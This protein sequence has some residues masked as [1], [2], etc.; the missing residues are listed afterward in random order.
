[1]Q[2]GR[3]SALKNRFVLAGAHCGFNYAIPRMRQR[4]YRSLKQT[5]HLIPFLQTFPRVIEACWTEDQK[6]ERYWTL[7][8]TIYTGGFSRFASSTNAPIATALDSYPLWANT[9]PALTKVGLDVC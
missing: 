8:T 9:F 2:P 4:L 3:C 1:M 5:R 7:P 6:C